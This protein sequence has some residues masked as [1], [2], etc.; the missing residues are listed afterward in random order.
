MAQ[1][2]SMGG[3][4]FIQL[5]R[6][7]EPFLRAISACSLAGMSQ[8]EGQGGQRN[9]GPGVGAKIKSLLSLVFTVL[10]VGASI[11]GVNNVFGV[12]DEVLAL[13]RESACEGQGPSCKAEMTLFEAS[14]FSHHYNMS[15]PKGSMSITCKRPYIFLGPFGCVNGN[16]PS[17]DAAAPAA[18]GSSSAG[19]G[20]P[21]KPAKAGH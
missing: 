19:A 20:K 6:A 13:A 7:E 9:E 16:A 11:A 10:L 2:A 8:A 18:S 12:R 4:S 5:G 21:S 1:K 17:A 14:P 15:T 3:S